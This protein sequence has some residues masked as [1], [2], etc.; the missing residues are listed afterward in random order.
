MVF[1]AVN[2]NPLRI[3]DTTTP[4]VT[5]YGACNNQP[6]PN[7]KRLRFVEIRE[8]FKPV[9]WPLLSAST[10]FFDELSGKIA[11][12]AWNF[13]LQSLAPRSRDN[14]KSAV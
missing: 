6:F 13:E 10:E 7:L 1:G 14:H 4:R 9:A 2:G 11:R 8:P 5:T 12:C 3:A